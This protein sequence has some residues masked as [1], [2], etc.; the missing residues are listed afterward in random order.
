MPYPFVRL[1]FLSLG[2]DEYVLN[3]SHVRAD[4]LCLVKVVTKSASTKIIEPM[5]DAIHT[6]LHF[7]GG[8]VTG[9]RVIDCRRERPHERK[10]NDGDTVYMNLGGEYRISV[11]EG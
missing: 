8:T 10:E 4:P 6:A 9:G 3:G 5:V 11:S 1:D 7:Q 2:N